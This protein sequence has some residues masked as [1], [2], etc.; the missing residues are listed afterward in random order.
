MFLRMIIHEPWVDP[1]KNDSW[2][3]DFYGVDGFE[4]ANGQAGCRAQ[5]YAKGFGYSFDSIPF[6][7][8]EIKGIYAKDESKKAKASCYT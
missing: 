1:F 5:F 4:S 3:V 7:V 6:P 8:E 2:V